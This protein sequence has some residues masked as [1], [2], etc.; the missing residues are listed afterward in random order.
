[1][2]RP[3]YLTKLNQLNSNV[4][5]TLRILTPDGGRVMLMDYDDN[6]FNIHNVELAEEGSSTVSPVLRPYDYEDGGNLR[7]DS[8]VENEVFLGIT[9]QEDNQWIEEYSRGT[10]SSAAESRCDNVWSEATSLESVEMLLKSVGQGAL[11]TESSDEPGNLATNMDPN[12]KQYDE[13]NHA[14]EAMV[15]PDKEEGGTLVTESRDEP[16]SLATNMDPNLKLDDENNHAQETMVIDKE[17]EGALAAEELDV[18]DEPCCLATNMDPNLKL[19]D[20]NNHAQEAMVID[21]EEEGALAAEELDVSDEPGSLSINMDPN[22]KQDDVNSDAQEAML[23]DKEEEGALA[24]AELDVSDEPSS[25]SMNMY[26]NLKQDDENNH[27]HEAM[28]TNNEAMVTN[29]EEEVALATEELDVSDEPVSLSKNMDPNLKQDDENKHAQQAMVTNKEEEGALATEELDVSDEPG[30]LVINMDPS[31]KQDDG[32][33]HAQEAVVTSKE[34]GALVIEELDASDDPG[35]LTINMDP[36]LKQDD[37]YN[38]AQEAMVTNKVEVL[39]TEELDNDD[40]GKFTNMDPN[41]EQDDGNNHAYE[42]IIINKPQDHFSG[43]NASFDCQK[44]NVTITKD[45]HEEAKVS[46]GELNSD[47]LGKKCD[48][49]EE[50]VDGI[51][52]DV[53]HEA[54]NIAVELSE[55]KLQDTSTSKIECANLDASEECKLVKCPFS[56]KVECSTKNTDNPIGG[57]TAVETCTNTDENPSNV[58]SLD[59]PPFEV[60]ISVDEESMPAGSSN[61]LM[62]AACAEVSYDSKCAVTAFPEARELNNDLLYEDLP[63]VAVENDDKT[64]PENLVFLELNVYPPSKVSDVQSRYVEELE[65]PDGV[66][67]PFE[68]GEESSINAVGNMRNTCSSAE[69]LAGNEDLVAA[70]KAHSGNSKDKDQSPAAKLSGSVQHQV[71]D[72]IQSSEQDGGTCID[73]DITL[74]EEG[75]ARLP[76]DMDIA[77]LDSQKNVES[78]LS[79]EGCNAQGSEADFIILAEPGYIDAK[80]TLILGGMSS[81]HHDNGEKKEGVVSDGTC[82][83]E[84]LIVASSMVDCASSSVVETGA[85]PD[86]AGEDVRGMSVEN[87]NEL[88]QEANP[89]GLGGCSATVDPMPSASLSVVEI[90]ASPDSSGD[91]RGTSVENMNAILNE[92]AQEAN[93]G[94][95]G[96]CSTPATVDPMPSASLSVVETGASPDSSGELIRETSVENMNAI[97]NELAQEAHSDGWGGCS[98]PSTVDPIPS[99]S[100]AKVGDN[101]EAGGGIQ[102]SISGHQVNMSSEQHASTDV[103]LTSE[104]DDSYMRHEEDSLLSMDKLQSVSP[105]L[106]TNNNELSQ[107]TRVK[108]VKDAINE[109]ASLPEATKDVMLTSE[110]DDSHMRHEEDSSVFIDKHQSVFLLNTNNTEFSQNTR[111]KSIEDAINEY[112]SLPEAT[113]DVVPTSKCD[114][115]HMRHEEDS[116]VSMDKHQSVSLLN[117]NNTEL[118]QDTRVK[119]FEDAT[120]ENASLPEATDN[121]VLASECDDSHM[122]HVEDSSVSMDKLQSVSS[123]LLNTNNTEPSQSTRVKPSKGAINENVSLPEATEDLQGKEQSISSN[124]GMKI[125]K[126]F[127]FEVSAT[128]VLGETG[129]GLHIFPV[130]QACNLSTNMEVPCVESISSTLDPRKPNEAPAV[131]LQTPGSGT[132]HPGAKERKTRRKSV[133]KES[134]KKGKEATT[135]QLGRVEKSSPLLVTP[136]PPIAAAA[137]HV[138][139]F[140]ELR[141]EERVECSVTKPIPISN[142]PDLNNAT[143]LF[144]QP[145]TNN[146]QFQL[147]AQILVYGSL[148]SGTP[149]EEPHMI[150]AFGQSD[151]GRKTWEAAWH[152]CL[153]RIHGQKSQANTPAQPRSDLKDVSHRSPDLGIKHSS[154]LSSSNKGTPP[155]VSPLI[156]VTSP[157]WN[158]STPS[159]VGFHSRSAAFQHLFTPIHPT[160]QA[161]PNPLWLS[162][163]PFLGQ[164]GV[165]SSPASATPRFSALPITEAVKLTPVK[166]SGGGPH[167]YSKPVAEST[168]FS[169]LSTDGKKASSDSKSRKRKKVA[170]AFSSVP[171]QVLMTPAHLLPLTGG[172]NHNRFPFLVENQTDSVTAPVTSIFSTSVTVSTPP[173]SKSSSPGTFLSVHGCPRLED[174]KVGDADDVLLKK[175]EESNVQL[176]YVN[177]TKTWQPSSESRSIKR[178]KVTTSTAVSQT[179]VSTPAPPALAHSPQVLGSEIL[180]VAQNQTISATS[181]AFCTSFPTSVAMSTPVSITSDGS[182]NGRFLE[183][184]YPTASTH[185][186]PRTVYQNMENAPAVEEALSKVK[187][188]KL[189]AENAALLAAAEV[190]NCQDVWCGLD[191]QKNSGGVADAE[192]KLISSIAAAAAVAKMASAAAKIASNVAEQAKLVA[193]E[194]FL[195]SKTENFD[196]ISHPNVVNKA[197][198]TSTLKSVDKTTNNHPNS[199]ISAAREAARRR[200]EAASAASKHAEN[201]D[202]IVKAAE[203]AAEAVSQVGKI[204]AMHDSSALR[205][206][207]E[208]G[209]EGFWKISQLAYELHQGGEVSGLHLNS[210]SGKKNVPGVFIE[211]IQTLKHGKSPP[212]RLAQNP[213]MMVIDDGSITGVEKDTRTSTVPNLSKAVG[214]STET[215]TRSP[216]TYVVG[217]NIPQNTPSLW[218][219]HNIKE[220]CLVEVYKVDGKYKGAWLAANILSLKD[221]KAL[222]CYT[223]IQSSDEGSEEVKEWVAFEVEGSEEVPKIRIAHPMTTMRFEG[224]RK[225]RRTAITDYAW[226]KGDRVDVWMQDC[227]REGVVMEPNKIDATSLTVQFPASQ[228][229]TSAVRSWHVRPTLI[230]KDRKWIEWKGGHASQGETPK[231]KRMKLGSL[232]AVDDKRKD[233][234]PMNVEP[235]RHEEQGTLLPLISA[236][237]ISFNVGKSTNKLSSNL[238]TIQKERARVVFGVPKPGKKQKFMD[239][240]TQFVND[241]SNK[242][243]TTNGSFKFSKPP[244]TRGSKTGAT[245]NQVTET[246]SRLKS[247]KPPVPSFRTTSRDSETTDVDSV[248]NSS[249]RQNQTQVGSSSNKSRDPAK[250]PTPKKAFTFTFTSKPKSE[251]FNRGKLQMAPK[252]E[253]KDKSNPEVNEPRR[254]NRRI[255]PTSRLLEGLQSSLTTSKI[256]SAPHI[257]QRKVAPKGNTNHG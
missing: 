23:V 221:E 58:E 97:M 162:Q 225:R 183:T 145:F 64:K 92:L 185:G 53:N 190:S 3:F 5:P 52:D 235:G 116:S 153:E 220:G 207:A 241:R 226:S 192:A 239:V 243:N 214:V 219:E 233:K 124:S 211:E 24:T 35:K 115:S 134:V 29:K 120:N 11:V 39:V 177:A 175:V 28:V 9:G 96:G 51:C 37:G 95:L 70:P 122:R 142:L 74:H 4:D 247:R 201:L 149:P 227:W 10:S 34:V 67:D 184:I 106:N 60:D 57:H 22:L 36:N 198:P 152:A 218:E 30:I 133:G 210:N 132:I 144:H 173:A 54:R 85:S 118:S 136:P 19:D 62:T 78:V 137:G 244:V 110:C 254:S 164:W 199:I 208:A 126:S 216:H 42:A 108:P 194:V 83:N 80:S 174:K 139:Q 238:R 200:I 151:A 138:I 217:H 72:G 246:K 215:N 59:K 90:G 32:N 104:C 102:D 155:A 249:S 157:L 182:P 88:A 135:I 79:N 101:V 154:T 48:L 197:T 250:G 156:H 161:P 94:G 82:D 195:S 75:N 71:N 6:E 55:N 31:L 181:P 93:P 50:K 229:E 165:A 114:D 26:P 257:S 81:V 160:Y 253:V 143:C 49:S 193:D 167:T 27:A 223:G 1:M 140:Q 7:F 212:L 105:L 180:L 25:L 15:T 33:N 179:P 99:E 66:F 112:A 127:T 38:H 205:K 141:P 91:V 65:K 148:I 189:H 73:R 56:N 100:S 186:Y 128:A 178:T 230:W 240:S 251:Q 203:L 169:S 12:L 187:E 98:T 77:E 18:S 69:L 188:S 46:G 41:L 147:R 209:P 130:P 202:A 43:S 16:C 86:S 119:P 236:L 171:S 158:M 8:L 232:A 107:S 14:R 170:A 256:P 176:A 44:V 84:S 2:Y 17:E 121:L 20:E 168:V 234:L 117:T 204:V 242:S 63:Q 228:G 103:V 87:M 89:G 146:Q 131:T 231:E 40:L 213:M 206:L 196:H 113:E 47:V 163:G 224:A 125:D 248:E 111:V 13:N 129:K 252:I 222:V 191:S 45:S 21:K 159:G 68:M 109:S 245:E 166:V 76:L 237:E 255:Q 61:L 123:P 150:A 172:H